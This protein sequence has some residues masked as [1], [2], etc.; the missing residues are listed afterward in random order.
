MDF[1]KKKIANAMCAH[2]YGGSLFFSHLSFSRHIFS[3]RLSSVYKRIWNGATFFCESLVSPFLN[4]D[5]QFSSFHAVNKESTQ[6]RFRM[7]AQ[8]EGSTLVAQL[9]GY[10]C[11]VIS[12]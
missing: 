7:Q 11:F 12:V 4:P 9:Y 3:L 8:K 2:R 1:E 5:E 6:R 10:S